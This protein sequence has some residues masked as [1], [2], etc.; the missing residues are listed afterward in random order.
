[1]FIGDKK[2]FFIYSRDKIKRI[3]IRALCRRKWETWLPE[4]WRY[5][6]H[7]FLSWSSPA[8][9]PATASKSE[10]TKG[11]TENEKLPEVGNY[12]IQDHLRNLKVLKYLEHDEIYLWHLKQLASEVYKPLSI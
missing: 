12:Q 2:N 11:G 8:S 6:A 3:E 7:N 9:A 4:I 1:M 10:K 5:E